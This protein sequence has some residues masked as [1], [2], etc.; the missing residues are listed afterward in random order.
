MKNFKYFLKQGV[1]PFVY[2]ILMSISAI[3]INAIEGLLPLKIA[4]GILNLLLYWLVIGIVSFRDGQDAYN[5]LLANDALRRRIIATGD[6]IELNTAKEYKWWKGAMAGLFA[7]IP[8]IIML[9]IHLILTLVNPAN[10]G[11]GSVA[12]LVYAVTNIFLQ[13]AYGSLNLPANAYFLLF[14]TIP[15]F[16]FMTMS[17]YYIGARKVIARQHIV[18][19]KRKEIYGE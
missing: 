6:D 14:L 11:A 17:A 9:I 18:E 2:L 4:L 1:F 8:L 13:L 3:A 15:I 10:A 12:G 19:K 5:I 7:C 16:M